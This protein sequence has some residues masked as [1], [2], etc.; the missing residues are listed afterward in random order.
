[1]GITFNGVHSSIFGLGTKIIRPLLPGNSDAYID[2][3]GR[4]GS[5][6]FPGKPKDRFISVEF[7]FMPTTRELFRSKVWEISAWLNVEERKILI[8]DDEPGKYYI[9][10]VEDQVDLEQAYLLGKFT[11]TF[12]W[13]PFAYGTE[14]ISNFVNDS[15]IIS[16]AGTKP[17]P[18]IIDATFAGAATEFKVALGT[19]YIRVVNTF[20][21]NDTL[22]IDTGTGA[23]LING[24]R[25]MDK[26]DWQSSQYFE[27]A[28]G[29]NTLAITPA[30][31]CT[32]TTKH[33]PRWL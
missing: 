3:H 4:A 14:V 17:T 10:K 32:A 18:A 7:G 33:V 13:E 12:R 26:L 16:N 2:V 25:A 29:N 9:G 21:I 5:I 23:V 11:A 19:D 1:M 22:H 6:L 31:V 27:L 15:V 20:A 30:G 28:V 8:I 24:L